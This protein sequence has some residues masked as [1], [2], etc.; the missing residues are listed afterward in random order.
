LAG[1]WLNRGSWHVTPEGIEPASADPTESTPILHPFELGKY[2]KIHYAI[3]PS[4]EVV[5]TRLRKQRRHLPGFSQDAGKRTSARW[6]GS[7]PGI[8]PVMGAACDNSY[9]SWTPGPEQP[10]HPRPDVAQRGWRV[11]SSPCCAKAR[12]SS[13][14]SPTIS[15]VMEFWIFWI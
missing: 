15:K 8:S 14:R 11:D 13:G 2:D 6:L 9:P 10:D 3:R 12:P 1:Q 4:G 7:A 5:L